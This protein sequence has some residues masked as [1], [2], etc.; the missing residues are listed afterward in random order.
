MV[1]LIVL[2]LHRLKNGRASMD[3]KSNIIDHPQVRALLQQ[4]VDDMIA[5]SPPG[6][7]YVLDLNALQVPTITFL[8]VWNA[9]TLLGCGALS[10]LG[11]NSGE[12]KSMRTHEDHLGKGV[13]RALLDEIVRLAKERGY[14][15]LSLETG[16]G[17]TFERA[18]HLYKKY[19]FESGAPFGDYKDGDFNQFFHLD[20]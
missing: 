20:L 3:I 9:E 6:H 12:L 13:A 2:A 18:I 15:R 10:D 19:G 5:N 17:S 8:T 7:A 1:Q 4:H 11:N 16:R 14:H